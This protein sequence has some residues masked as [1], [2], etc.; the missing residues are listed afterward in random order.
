VQLADG[1]LDWLLRCLGDGFALLV[2][3]PVD[4]QLRADV[5][6]AG[7]A[8]APVQ[9]LSIADDGDLRD[10]E[11]LLAQRYDLQPGTAV[12]LRPDQHVCARWRRFDAQAL[13]AGLAR[14]LA[15]A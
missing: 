13:R 10:A 4:A 8:L 5:R 3:G 6:R 12:L 11:G 1:S 2:A 7:E 15:R 9:V 14:A